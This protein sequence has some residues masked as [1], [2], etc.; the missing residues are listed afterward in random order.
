M[1]SRNSFSLMVFMLIAFSASAQ[2]YHFSQFYASPLSLNPALTGSFYSDYRISAIYRNQWAG[3]NSKFETYALG[4]DM[5]FRTGR[6]K[7]DLIGAGIYIYRDNLG[8]DI[9]IAQSI[10]F[11]G[12]Y[13]HSLDVYNRHRLSGGLQFGYVQKSIDASKLTFSDQYEDFELVPGL[14]SGDAFIKDQINYFNVNIG[15]FY[16]FKV[17]TKTDFF[18]GITIFQAN[19]PKESFFSSENKLNHRYTGYTG[20]NYKINPV[21]TISPKLLYMNQENSMDLNAGASVGYNVRK[22]K[23]VTLYVGGWY[24]MSDAAII[25]SGAKWKNYTLRF[26]YD[27]TVSGLREVKKASN[28]KRNP[29]T[30]S[31]EISLIMTGKLSRTMADSYTVPCEIY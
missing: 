1:I 22:K 24:R 8:G 21:F 17:S 2:D 20:F 6:L 28:I 4:A 10:Q 31:F 9:F 18:T 12:A 30:G 7:R 11:S 15:A 3:I 16:S 14:G 13:H 26:S 19:D 29:K 27:A 25:M 23:D 5:N